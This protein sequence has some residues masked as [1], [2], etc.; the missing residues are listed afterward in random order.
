MVSGELSV[1]TG[2]AVPAAATTTRFI[3]W[4]CEGISAVVSVCVSAPPVAPAVANVPLA[5]LA[6][7]TVPESAVHVLADCPG[8]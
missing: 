1:G 7:V 2:L 4:L 8:R 5:A 6:T 3:T